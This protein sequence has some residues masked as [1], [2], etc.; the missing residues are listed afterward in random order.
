[1]S[2]L[3]IF[4]KKT[5]TCKKVAGTAEAA[6]IDGSMSDTS[7]NPVQNKV[8]KSYVDGRTSS[9]AW[10]NITGKPSTYTPSSHTHDDRYYTESEIN[11]KLNNKANVFKYDFSGHDVYICLG[12]A[13][14]RQEGDYLI[15]HI[16]SGSGCN[17]Y[18]GQDRTIDVHIRTSN[19]RPADNGKYYI[20]YIESHLNGSNNCN[21]YVVQ[22]SST[23]FTIWIGKL[24]YSGKSFYEVQFPYWDSWVPA[25]NNTSTTI[26]TN[27]VALMEKK[28]AYTDV[29]TTSENGLMSKDMVT[30]LNGI[31]DGANRTIV[32][33]ALS[34]TS[35]NP[36]QNKVVTSNLTDI[37][38]ETTVNLLNPTLQ[39]TTEDGV[40]CTN[41]GDGTYTLNGTS[42][43]DRWI[44]FGGITLNPGK[45]KFIATENNVEVSN[46]CVSIKSTSI[47]I[48][49]SKFTI[50]SKSVCNIGLST[51]NETF[52]N[53][54]LKP[55]LTTNLNATYDDF[56][57]YTGDTGRLNCDVSV[58]A[59]K[60]P[61]FVRNDSVFYSTAGHSPVITG[62]TAG[63]FSAISD[64]W[65]DDK[66]R[67]I[68]FKN[69]MDTKTHITIYANVHVHNV[70]FLQAY[71]PSGAAVEV[72]SPLFFYTQS[73]DDN[74]V[75]T[76]ACDVTAP[77]GT[78]VSI[79]F[80]PIVIKN[81]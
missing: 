8:V 55:M 62:N 53:I 68:K 48:P 13:T 37:R 47:A 67:V 36:V 32:D 38:K 26:P 15:L 44:S 66:G 41:N 80:N 56:V 7:T 69:N 57:P 17:G 11:T 35:T 18:I 19:G 60:I 63:R 65:S 16:Y 14:L 73:S 34:S 49:G 72:K 51:H 31:T 2:S 71:S 70:L 25:I 20:G 22:N 64:E 12:T 21:I 1:M 54:L 81:V 45:Y 59:K 43:K 42:T 61:K 76:I 30:K 79:A 24:N 77:V 29:A 46:L 33:D 10:N 50:Q 3:G 23:S 6:A 4:D 39:T 78:E 5:K 9:V 27:G 40:T 52:N 74:P 58:L 75:Q 28:I